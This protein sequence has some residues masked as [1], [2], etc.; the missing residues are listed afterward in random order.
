MVFYD[1]GVKV[2]DGNADT[3]LALSYL[4]LKSLG[5]LHYLLFNLRVGSSTQ[6]YPPATR[7]KITLIGYFS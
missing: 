3:L 1:I 5:G 4:G 6:C 2:G 7:L